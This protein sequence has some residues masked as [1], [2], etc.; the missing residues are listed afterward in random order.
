MSIHQASTPQRIKRLMKPTKN[1]LT[2]DCRSNTAVANDATA[3]L[4]HGNHKP[5]TNAS[6]IVNKRLIRKR[7]PITRINF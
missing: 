1:D 2:E 6:I 4:H 3:M 5:K 7:I